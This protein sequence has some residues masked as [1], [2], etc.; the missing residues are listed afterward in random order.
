MVILI[1]ARVDEPWALRKYRL[2][3]T[4]EVD[5]LRLEADFCFTSTMMK[6]TSNFNFDFNYLQYTQYIHIQ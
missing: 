2:R 6:Q 5:F 1:L 3:F 4:I